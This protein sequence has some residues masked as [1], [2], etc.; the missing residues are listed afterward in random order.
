MI[1]ELPTEEPPISRTDEA[2]CNSD[3]LRALPKFCSDDIKA[4][5]LIALLY[6]LPF[7]FLLLLFQTQSLS[8]PK[9]PD[10]DAES[11]RSDVRGPGNLS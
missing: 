8:F 11:F 2:F 1:Q 7:L 6:A 5:I 9:A 4:F 10:D 3:P